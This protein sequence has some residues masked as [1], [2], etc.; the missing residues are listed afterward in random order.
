ME[1]A[2]RVQ[3]Q[4]VR[5]W[6]TRWLPQPLV[7]V[8]TA[9]LAAAT[10]AAAWLTEGNSA[11]TALNGM[12]PASSLLALCL[13]A[14]VILSYQF[15]IHIRLKTKISMASIPLY[16]MAVLLPPP[17]AATAALLG[18][19][20]SELS[21][22]VQRGTPWSAVASGSARWA[23]IVLLGSLVAH[24]PGNDAVHTG[25]LVAAGVILEAGDMWS[26]PL[27][28]APL[29]GEPP[30]RVVVAAAR[31]A[32]L[33]EGAQYLL[34]LQGA[35]MA[36]GRLWS[37]ALLVLP[38]ILVYR[39]FKSAMELHDTT[40][41]MLEKMADTVDL[42]D[43][44]TGGHSR[45]VTD[46]CITILRELGR[47]GP[48]VDLIITA[49][50]VH[51]IGKIAISD[52]VLRK[53]GPLTTEER[54]IMQTHAERGA[55][56]LDRYVGFAQG[57]AIVRHHHESWDGTGY[58]HRLRETQIPFGARVI[59]VADSYDAMTSDRP[60]RSGM[61][62]QKAASMLREGRGRQWDP[63]I[64]DAFLRTMAGHLE[65]PVPVP[66]QLLLAADPAAA[67]PS[68]VSA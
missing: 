15:P 52:E 45:R 63:V 6:L 36:E 46:H 68:S 38:T 28:L 57:A 27:M 35:L 66:L 30:L 50:R 58:P 60:Y 49:A 25:C 40:R 3:A 51:D 9:V 44:Y 65:Q 47:K 10:V 24:L 13:V 7:G 21:V 54:L 32:W 14:A 29:I 1:E 16:L 67:T 56:L 53:P 62:P 17:L 11:A 59:A 5:D 42:R 61:P 23:P 22:R 34:G 4:G 20:T 2:G 31:E 33:A 55:D 41:Y 8:A 64:V 18:V 37:L 19:L 43:P 26:I 12:P 39:A 48:D